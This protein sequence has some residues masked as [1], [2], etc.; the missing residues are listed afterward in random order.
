MI[1]ALLI[2]FAVFGGGIWASKCTINNTS[3]QVAIEAVR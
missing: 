2:A 3:S 1:K